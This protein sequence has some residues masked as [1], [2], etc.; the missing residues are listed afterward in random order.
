VRAVF[1][2]HG[3]QP[4]GNFDWVVQGAVDRCY[5]P[6]FDLLQDFPAM[7]ISVHF[8]G[9]LLE[10]IEAHDPRLLDTM[11]GL[12][13]RGQVEPVAA[14]LYEPV[15]ALLPPRDRVSQVRAHRALLE[16]LFG[17]AP[18]VAWLT[19]R[20]WTQ[21]LAG[22]LAD[23]GIDGVTLDDLHFMSAG[24]AHDEL[25]E[26]FLTEHLGRALTVV[27]AAEELRRSVPFRP[28]GETVTFLRE[29][30]AAGAAVTV[31][32]DDIE[33][34][35]LW[36]RTYRTVYEEGW[37]RD[38]F[39]RLSRL[40]N[41]GQLD[42]VPLGQA[43]RDVPA[44]RRVYIPD[45]SYPE[46]LG[47]TLPPEAQGRQRALRAGLEAAGT[48]QDARPFLRAGTYLQFLAKYPE[49][50]HLHK[51][52][53]DVSA[54]VAKRYP[55]ARV[56]QRTGEP[57]AAMRALWRAQANCAYWHGLF[58]GTY[59]P[60]LRQALWRSLLLAERELAAD[61]EPQRA[62]RVFDLDAD[63]H[64]EA[65]I[66]NGAL[67]MVVAS[68][69]G[70]AMVELS[71]RERLVNLSDTLARQ[72]EAYHRA[73][74]FAPTHEMED[75]GPRP[76][77]P[78]Y[79]YDHGRRGSFVDRFFAAGPPLSR[80]EEPED[81]GDFGG[82]PYAMR[83]R[84]SRGQTV[85]TL[86]REAAVPGG[87]ARVDKTLRVDDAEP[88]RVQAQYSVTAVE[89]L[90]DARFGVE[91]N[92]AAYFP[93]DLRGSVYVGENAHDL[94]SGGAGPASAVILAIEEPPIRV[95]V[96]SSVEADIDVR[97]LTTVS[98]SE[99]GMES[100]RQG[101]ACVFTWPLRLAP[102]ERFA[103]TFQ[104]Q[105]LAVP[106]SEIRGGAGTPAAASAR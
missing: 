52:M 62:L 30:A 99:A 47:W 76:D 16:R 35:G 79:P 102:G 34:F 93:E 21:E 3:H 90:P 74:E 92:F 67:F 46:M 42:V 39:E 20:V 103:V 97:P 9:S 56:A 19:E 64:D 63:G 23:A 11:R 57:P 22:D 100:I 85:V 84:R 8:S 12:V 49:V 68:G 91:C 81:R 55:T 4:P 27:P 41:D 15:L 70:G 94:L 104:M 29:R 106:V 36:P 37:L 95:E 40:V 48:W 51:R 72:P 17:I 31:Y 83:A 26:P 69:D 18:T 58:G 24:L 43:V 77:R 53:L 59:L 66:G 96:T 7:R 32:A 89:G 80:D 45:G 71:D 38:C 6:F 86:S 5:R 61:G 65:L 13:V 1:V 2:V 82:Q 105:L 98:Q 88:R 25:G 54:R 14:G 101:L 33:K 78:P 10:W 44:R 75:A 87:V 60:F 73:S 50:N 28:V